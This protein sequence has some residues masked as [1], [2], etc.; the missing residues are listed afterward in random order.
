MTWLELGECISKLNKEQ[1]RAP[2]TF[3]LLDAGDFVSLAED[4]MIYADATDTLPVGRPYL[5]V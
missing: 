1:L 3:M 2:V 5:M 4:R